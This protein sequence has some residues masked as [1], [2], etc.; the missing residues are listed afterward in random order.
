MKIMYHPFAEILIFRTN[1]HSVRD[2]ARVAP[3]LDA[4]AG[5]KRW[6]VDRDDVDCVLRI[7][8]DERDTEHVIHLVNTAGFLCEE[9][10]D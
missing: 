1:I 3:L 8:A 9:L 4:L 5:I 2:V 10:P 6:N 7:E